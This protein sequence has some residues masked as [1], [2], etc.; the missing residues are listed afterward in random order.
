MQFLNNMAILSDAS[1]IESTKFCTLAKVTIFLFDK[2]PRCKLNVG[3]PQTQ[4]ITNFLGTREDVKT[5]K[6]NL[7]YLIGLLQAH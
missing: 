7:P 3:R 6:H 4:P 1:V 5:L 2:L